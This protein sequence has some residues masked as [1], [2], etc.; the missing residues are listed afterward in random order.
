MPWNFGGFDQNNSVMDEMNMFWW[1]V[2]GNSNI[3]WK[4]I[5]DNPD[6]FYHWPSISSNPNIT[7]D[8]ILDNI[9]KNWAWLYI[10]ENKNLTLELINA[11]KAKDWSWCSIS[12]NAMT[13]QRTDFINDYRLKIIKCNIIKRFWR[14]CTYNPEYSLARRLVLQRAE[15]E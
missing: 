15:I 12:E 6:I 7:S 3:S 10:S 8:I 5:E 11:T 1:G 14:N 13:T 4:L 2:S 9:D